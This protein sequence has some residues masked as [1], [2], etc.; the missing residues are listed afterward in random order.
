MKKILGS[1]IFLLTISSLI[2]QQTTRLQVI[3]N[4]A[5]PVASVVDVYVNGNLAIDDFGFR[6]ATPF[7]DIPAN[8]LLNIGIA[9]G[10]SG[11][12]NDTIKNFQATLN[13]NKKYVLIANGVLD[14]SQFSPNPDGKSIS[15]TLFAKDNIREQG[16][17]WNKVDFIVVHGSTD[18]PTVDFIADCVYSSVVTDITQESKEEFVEEGD[19]WFSGGT[20]I[21]N[22]ASYGDITNYK[23]LFPDEYILKVTPGNNNNIVV[24]EFEARS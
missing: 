4:A 24:A 1:F 12:V 8:T 15:F 20:R 13:K 23:R 18:A 3:H 14:P 16:V 21:V 7:I 22:N 10:N 6:T 9:P 11:S 19:S 2:A 5:D 17:S